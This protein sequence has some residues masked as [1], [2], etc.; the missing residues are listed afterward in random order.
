MPVKKAAV[1]RCSLTTAGGRIDE[2]SGYWGT[3]AT[4]MLWGM[5]TEPRMI[6]G[7][8]IRLIRKGF[9]ATCQC[10]MTKISETKGTK[11]E[12]KPHQTDV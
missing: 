6:K 2:R 10:T 8:E 9:L 3:G 1:A 4:I 7:M 12:P 5:R 11:I